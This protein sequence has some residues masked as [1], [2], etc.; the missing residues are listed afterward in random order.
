MLCYNS[1][2]L[3]KGNQNSDETNFPAA[4]PPSQACSWLPKA[5]EHFGRT[6]CPPQTT[7]PRPPG[8]YKVE[9]RREGNRSR[10]SSVRTPEASVSGHL[11]H[12]P[13]EG[14][15]V[16]AMLPTE[17]RL[18]ANRDFRIVYARGRSQVHALAV[19]YVWRRT[20]DAAGAAP[21][22]RIGFVVSKKQGAAVVRNRIK[23]RLREAVRLRLP[24][25]REGMFDII[26]VGR[27]RLATASWTEVC[28]AVEELLRRG[29]LMRQESQTTLLPGQKEGAD[30]A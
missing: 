29:G 4:Q 19:V 18:R 1:R 13:A 8:T 25:L 22:R 16:Q 21:G 15:S 11:P 30:G 2:N 27:S 6:Q 12:L 7:R 28:C 20:G 5:H 23:R 26:F 14:Y 17:Q 24:V 10:L 3:S 9:T